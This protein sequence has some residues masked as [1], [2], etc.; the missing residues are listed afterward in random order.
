MITQRLRLGIFTL[1]SLLLTL[2]QPAQA[3]SSS[4]SFIAIS[5]SAA[6][7]MVR[8]DV[9][10]RDADLVFDLDQDRDGQ[11]RW[12]EVQAQ[13]APIQTW[14]G[15]SVQLQRSGQACPLQHPDLQASRRGDGTYISVQ[16]PVACPGSAAEPLVL[17]FSLLFDRDP[18]HRGLLTYTVDGHTTSA[19][20]SPERQEISL[21]AGGFS[22]WQIARRY[23]VEGIWHIW[24]GLDHVL[25]LIS[26]LLLA[27]LVQAAQTLMGRTGRASFRRMAVDV[28]T[29]VTAFTLAH[30]ITL[31]LSVLQLLRPS[32]AYIEPAIALSVSLAAFNNLLGAKAIK[33]WPVAFGFGLIHGFGFANVLLDLGLPASALAVA[34]G[35]FNVGVEL[36]QLAI[37][38]A[39]L[40]LAWWLR[41]TR[42]Y[43]QLCVRAG[44]LLIGLLG[45][46]WT[47]ERMGLLPGL[48]LFGS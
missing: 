45:G 43:R 31:A 1:L 25:F 48:A 11:V 17:N 19:L 23:V 28:L 3:H 34:L 30:S 27:P 9:S 21:P 47:L 26:L 35:G 24:I 8:L 32:P 20:L 2:A 36:G 44:S 40:P 42:L 5:P 33:R 39:F 38:L 22:V 4:N 13:S 6:G 29:V 37:V 15:D 18:L 14:L 10:V 16:W 41:D 7:L 12:S 46:Y